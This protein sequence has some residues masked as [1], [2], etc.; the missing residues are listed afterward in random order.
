MKNDSER[1]YEHPQVEVLEIQI[2]QAILSS[3]LPDYEYGGDPFQ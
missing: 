2:E 3:S 1:N